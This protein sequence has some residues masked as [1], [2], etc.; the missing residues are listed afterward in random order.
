MG[1]T[2]VVVYRGLMGC[3]EPITPTPLAERLKLSRHQ[4]QRALGKLAGYKMARREKQGWVGIKVD[5]D[6]LDRNV[7][8]PAGTLGKGEARKQEHIEERAKRAGEQ[9]LRARL[10]EER[11]QGRSDYLEELLDK[12]PYQDSHSVV[13]CQ[14]CGQGVFVFEGTLP[15]QVCTFCAENYGWKSS[16][17]WLLSPPV[18]PLGEDKRRKP[19][20]KKVR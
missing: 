3:A 9:L 5:D 18:Q 16:S 20:P 12:E 7:A 15:P 19:P 4:V 14:N 1:K 11:R 8:G 13:Y 10:A 6:W 17:I 2:A